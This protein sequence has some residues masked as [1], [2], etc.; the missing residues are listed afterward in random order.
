MAD[1]LIKNARIITC[2]S[3]GPKFGKEMSDLGVIE[4]GFI[5][6]E[7]DKILELGTGSGEGF[8][9]DDTII[10]DASGKTVL[11]GLVDPHTHLVHYGSR[12]NE[13]EMKLKGVPYLEILQAGGGI[14]STVRATRGASFEQLTEKVTNSLNK[15]LLWGTTTVEAK[16]GYGLNFEDEVKCLE[17]LRD[18]KHPVDIVRT[19]MG[20]HAVPTEFKENREA[21]IKLMLDE[22]IPYVAENKLA[23]F[24][25]CFCEHGVFSIEESEKILLEGRKYGLSIKMHADE[26]EPM[27]GAELAGRLK[28]ISSEH[29][30]AASD[31]GIKAL[32]EG[33]V[34]PVLLPGTSFYLRIGKYAR[35]REMINQGLPVALATDYNPGS[36]PTESLQSIMVFAGMGMGLTPQEVINAMTINSA[37]AINRG[38]TVGSLEKGKIADIVIMDVPNENYIIYHFGIN[39]VNTVIKRGRIVVEEGRLV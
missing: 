5:A 17:V 16:S 14:L 2:K 4:N 38:A 19:Y 18:I 23:E 11:P 24:I 31:E 9:S 33:G 22:V 29:L 37:H 6:I 20:A 36:C 35:G 12:E 27:G 25:D 10:I 30:I 32:K 8:I 34:I 3:N 39:H 7:K 13:L 15:M 21:Y 1:M 26:I 28:A